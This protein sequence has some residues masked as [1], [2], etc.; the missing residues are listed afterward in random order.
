MKQNGSFDL[1]G[2]L[3]TSVLKFRESSSPDDNDR[4]DLQQIVRDA[5]I[6]SSSLIRE[7]NDPL[8]DMRIELARKLL[9]TYQ[10]EKDQMQQAIKY[11]SWLSIST[12]LEKAIEDYPSLRHLLTYY[13]VRGLHNLTK[14]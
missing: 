3:F 7:A 4:D 2:N 14:C 6:P 9:R 8:S 10:N 11:D 13:N 5:L 1:C 12:F